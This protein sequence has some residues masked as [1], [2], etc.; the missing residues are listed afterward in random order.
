MDRFQSIMLVV[1]LLF[2]FYT[3]T[4][5]AMHMFQQNRYQL[6]RYIVW[7]KQEI[8]YRRKKILFTFLCL[9]ATYGLYLV[10]SNDLP[11][12]LLLLL[13]LIYSYIF[14]RMEDQRNYRKPM[15]FTHRIQRLLCAFYVF[16]FIM[17][18]FMVWVVSLDVWIALIPFLY[19]MPW[20]ALIAIA[21]IMQPI[22]ERIRRYFVH[23]AQMLLRRHKDLCIV[24]ITGSYG[25]T[26][27]KNILHTLLSDTYY[28]LM[29]PQSYNNMMGITLSIREHLQNLHEVFLCEMGADHVHEIERLMEFVKPRF[30]IVSA[31]GPQHLST[32]HSLD[33]I[34]HEKMQ[35]IEK[36]PANGV[37][38]INIDNELIR[39]Y[40]IHNTCRI[41]RYGTR[42]EADVRVCDIHY[43][44]NGSSFT[45]VCDNE[46][47]V[48]TT[49]L[50]GRH[51]ILNIAAGIAVARTMHVEW[52][53][54]QK[55]CASLDYVE[56]RLQVRN[57]GRYTI[58]D[59]AYNSNPEGADA[60]LEVL[61]QME[62]KRIIV[63]PGF[64][65][66]GEEGMQAHIRLGQQIA[67]CVDEVVLVGEQQ[68]K[69]I[70]KGLR[71]KQFPLT[72]LHV[73][74]GID[75]AFALLNNLAD[76]DTTVLLENDLPD[77]FN[78]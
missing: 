22:E 33:N 19:F 50:L 63:T 78:H 35:M 56:H 26:S 49:R 3:P 69:D 5:Q 9:M 43:T 29:T 36:L 48:F 59:N 32:F 7:L 66:L 28:T 52:D 41:V 14:F 44:K 13:L 54:L 72:H 17:L 46:R 38:F 51:N 27:V 58:L 65:D 2:F 1:I 34:L 67:S 23:D 16:Y 25:K 57:G 10:S 53:V 31:V 73:V 77:A 20:F 40:T 61:A 62:G 45:V 8:V 4:R 30:G 39:S 47:Y 55:L 18:L 12:I 11:S 70:V 37:G 6:P 21:L 42:E 15:V 71:K 76:T 68:T 64:L 24:G 60:S 74:Q 75:E